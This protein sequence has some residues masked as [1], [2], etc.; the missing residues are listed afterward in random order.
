[1]VDKNCSL[2]SGIN[3]GLYN[4]TCKYLYRETASSRYQEIDNTD[5]FDLWR[6]TFIITFFTPLTIILQYKKPKEILQMEK[7]IQEEFK[8]LKA[9]KD[10]DVDCT[11]S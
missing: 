11:P 4:K 5:Y 1:M 6:T 8:K 3:T 2:A 9:S 10:G 7:E